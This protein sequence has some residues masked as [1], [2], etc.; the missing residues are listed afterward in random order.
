MLNIAQ[1]NEERKKLLDA[2][3][4]NSSLTSNFKRYWLIPVRQG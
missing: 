1:I 4:V 2:R 3:T